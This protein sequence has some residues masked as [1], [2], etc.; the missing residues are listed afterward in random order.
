MV[1]AWRNEK[2]VYAARDFAPFYKS[3]LERL[4]AAIEEATSQI[5]AD[6]FSDEGYVGLAISVTLTY[7]HMGDLDRGLKELEAL[8][9]SNVKSR[10]QSKHRA[11]ILDDFRKGDSFKKLRVIKYGDP[12]M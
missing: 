6:E 10:E 2:Y 11:V 7:A 4:R 12:M 1:Y 5:T 8:L 9:T 3:E